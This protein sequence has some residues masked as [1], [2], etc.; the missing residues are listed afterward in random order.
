[1]YRS[2]KKIKNSIDSQAYVINHYVWMMKI[3]GMLMINSGNGKNCYLN[4]THEI[5][6]KY[7]RSNM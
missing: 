3:Y 2:F 5:Y 4:E 7:S 1:M 6:S